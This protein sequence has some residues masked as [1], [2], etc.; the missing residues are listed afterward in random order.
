MNQMVE[1]VQSQA[2]S[3]SASPMTATITEGIFVIIISEVYLTRYL[4]EAALYDRQIRLWGLEAQQKYVCIYKIHTKVS[5]IW[6][7]S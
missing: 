6:I 2:L 1:V 5:D 7:K 3:F 4:D